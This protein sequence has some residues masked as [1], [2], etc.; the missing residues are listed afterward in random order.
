M[1]RFIPFLLLT[2]CMPDI[3]YPAR[4][5]YQMIEGYDVT[6]TFRTSSHGFVIDDPKNELNDEVLDR[7]VSNVVK[8]LKDAGPPNKVQRREGWCIGD[9]TPEI[10]SCLVIK[11]APE[12]R[13]SCSGQGEVFSCAAPVESCR[14]KGLEPTAE[15]PCSC[16]AAVQGSGMIVTT[17]N[18]E[19]VPWRLVELLSG[20]SQI[21]NVLKLAECGNPNMREL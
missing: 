4:G 11:V 3:C 15:C 16:R 9:W 5:N 18:L 20:C 21:Q 2:S 10:R 7:T 1:I 17:P 12:W 19:L 14:A 6:P 8:C 13:P